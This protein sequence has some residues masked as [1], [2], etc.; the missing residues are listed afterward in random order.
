MRVCGELNGRPLQ[1][2]DKQQIGEHFHVRRPSDSV[3]P[4]A[5]NYN[6]APDTFQPVIR[7][8]RESGERELLMMGWGI[9]PWFATSELEF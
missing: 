2:L 1:P 7:R 8:R 3:G 9:V 6:I 5:R 4:I